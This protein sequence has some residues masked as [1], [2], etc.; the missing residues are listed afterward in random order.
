MTITAGAFTTPVTGSPAKSV[1]VTFPAATAGRLLVIGVINGA[2]TPLGTTTA[3]GFTSMLAD[4]DNSAV[5]GRLLGKI[6]A[7]GETT[8]T[9]ETSDTSDNLV[10]IGIELAGAW[11]G[12]VPTITPGT[13]GRTAQDNAASLV[14]P[15]ATYDG[16]AAIVGL[17]GTQ[18][19]PGNSPNP[20]ISG[21]WDDDTLDTSPNRR[22]NMAVA[23]VTGT[24][25][26]G[27]T[28]AIQTATN[29]VGLIAAI[30]EPAAAPAGLRA[31]LRL[32]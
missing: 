28:Y 27:A 22:G 20:T 16:H 26:K 19:L 7:G 31:G 25:S 29:M 10:A 8:V 15:A 5:N 11:G 1:V 13:T 17:F 9:V 12:V 4:T 2:S 23:V 3:T 6:A 30:H 21:S 32:R 14:V 24:S 18:A